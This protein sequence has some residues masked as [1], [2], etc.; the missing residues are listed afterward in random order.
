MEKTAKEVI[1]AINKTRQQIGT[2]SMALDGAQTHFI[3]ESLVVSLK[4]VAEL[5]YTCKD[6]DPDDW[7]SSIYG[8]QADSLKSALELGRTAI[9]SIKTFVYALPDNLRDYDSS[10]TPELLDTIENY[11]MEH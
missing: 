4:T 9:S 11:F 6:T 1:E 3:L 2:I 10:I 5:L 8:S 7:D